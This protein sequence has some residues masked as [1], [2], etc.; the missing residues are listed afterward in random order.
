MKRTTMLIAALLVAI[1]LGSFAVDSAAQ[2]VQT[3]SSAAPSRISRT[4][5]SPASP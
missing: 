5:P 3:G 1:V 4:C 2:G